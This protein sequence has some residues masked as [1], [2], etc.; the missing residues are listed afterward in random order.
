MNLS[1]VMPCYLGHYVGAASERAAKLHRAVCSFLQSLPGGC[2]ELVLVSDG[3]DETDAYWR[4]LASAYGAEGNEARF[5]ETT[6]MRHV[7]IDIRERDERHAGETRNRGI[8]A[9]TG[10]VVAYLD[11][12]DAFRPDHL[13]MIERSFGESD[14][15]WFDDLLW[16]ERYR[17]CEL[18]YGHIGT[19]CIA[20]RKSVRSRWTDGYGHDWRFVQDLMAE[21]SNY[22]YAGDGGYIVCHVPGCL[23]R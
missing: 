10:D 6:T 8:E 15:I 9:A 20:H 17:R 14:W 22:R 4:K 1:I 16:P 19:S 11:S 21:T 7:R 2:R 5:N 12:D 3:C 13:L 23:D 18:K